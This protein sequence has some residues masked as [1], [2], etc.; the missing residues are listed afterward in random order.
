[1]QLDMTPKCILSAWDSHQQELRAF[2][3]VRTNH[4]HEADDLLQEI[5]IKLLLQNHAFCGIQNTRA[6]LFRVARNTLTDYFRTKKIFVE[7]SAD[8]ALETSQKL[9]IAELETC[10]LRN[11]ADLSDDDRSV[12]ECCDLSGQN[13]QTYAIHHDLTLSAVKSRLLRARKKLRDRIILNCRVRFDEDNKVCC[14]VPR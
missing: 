12:I 4:T 11:L 2:L 13:Q 14:H 6:W 10:L 7:L 3:Q 9:P 5:F 1:M 8:L